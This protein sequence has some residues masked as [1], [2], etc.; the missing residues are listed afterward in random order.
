MVVPKFSASAKRESINEWESTIPVLGDSK[1]L[2]HR[3]SGSIS[4]A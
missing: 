4:I 3:S 2:R 1:A